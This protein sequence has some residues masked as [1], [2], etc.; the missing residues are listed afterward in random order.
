MSEPAG[1]GR[2]PEHMAPDPAGPAPAPPDET[3]PHGP[4][5][6]NPRL[7]HSTTTKYEPGLGQSRTATFQANRSNQLNA[8]NRLG[9]T[10]TTASWSIPPD[11]EQSSFKFA[12]DLPA[13]TIW[14]NPRPEQNCYQHKHRQAPQA[15]AKSR[16]SLVASPIP[17]PCAL[18]PSPPRHA[19][20]VT[21]PPTHH[22]WYSLTGPG[23]SVT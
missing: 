5:K 7:S 22:I 4:G 21:L 8:H 23:P 19:V 16:N 1:P 13:A 10:R 11:H 9:Q 2:Q 3:A 14:I 18:A 20:P 15:H 6:G 12:L 17:H